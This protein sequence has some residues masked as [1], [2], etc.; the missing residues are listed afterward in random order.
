MGNLGDTQLAYRTA[1]AM[2]QSL[3]DTGGRVTPLRDYKYEDLIQWFDLAH[4]LDP[5]ADFV[6]YI[7][8]YYFGGLEGDPDQLRYIV[9]YLHKVVTRRRA[10][11]GALRAA[12]IW[13]GISSKT[14]IWPQLWRMI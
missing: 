5:Q 3:G 1:A 7:A 6:P 4:D 13:R 10:I 2:L 9:N 14:Q 12:Y 11:N 8:A